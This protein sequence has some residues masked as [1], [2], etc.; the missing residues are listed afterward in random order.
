MP[1]RRVG[2]FFVGY[3][4][5][6]LYSERGDRYYIGSSGNPEERLVHHNSTERGFTSRYRPWR[7]VY[8]RRFETKGEALAAER[9]IKGWKSRKMIAA[10]IEGVLQL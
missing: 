8:T 4:I 2:L 1:D 10:L 3:W 5:Y 7:I 9:K 6:I